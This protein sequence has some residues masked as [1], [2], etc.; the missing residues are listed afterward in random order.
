MLH[1]I[2]SHETII[3]SAS[4]L[5]E[6]YNKWKALGLRFHNLHLTSFG[7][8]LKLVNPN[9]EKQMQIYMDKKGQSQPIIG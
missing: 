3:E 4:H 9:Y 6:V 5:D 8:V 7:F 2:Y 1:P